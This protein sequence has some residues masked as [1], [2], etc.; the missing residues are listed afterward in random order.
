VL[1]RDISPV[2]WQFLELLSMASAGDMA[3]FDGSQW[4]LVAASSGSD[5][6]SLKLASGEPKWLA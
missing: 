2:A 1:E 5:G 4:V 3:F 6:D